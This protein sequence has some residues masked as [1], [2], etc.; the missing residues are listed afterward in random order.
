MNWLSADTTPDAAEQLHR[1]LMVRSAEARIRMACDMFESARALV[2]ASLQREVAQDPVRRAIAV[3]TRMYAHDVDAT[4][5][6]NVID[7]LRRRRGRS[8]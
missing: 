6:T 7:D 5:L 1:L 4:F 3:L 8:D 2:I